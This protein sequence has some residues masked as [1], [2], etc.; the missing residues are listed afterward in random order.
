MF[1]F[2]Y[3][4]SV[5]I[6]QYH[7]EPGFPPNFVVGSLCA[8]VQQLRADFRQN[9]QMIAVGWV[10]HST[11][12]KKFDSAAPNNRFSYLDTYFGHTYV[13]EHVT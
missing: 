12:L 7:S 2:N 6:V 3:L 11:A 8:Y 1:K 5:R 9:Q 4:I 10:S 13:R